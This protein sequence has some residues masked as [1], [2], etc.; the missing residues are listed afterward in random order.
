MGRRDLAEPERRPVRLAERDPHDRARRRPVDHT[1]VFEPAEE[2]RID[3]ATGNTIPA[4]DWDSY[5]LAGEAEADYWAW[6][7]AM[8]AANVEM[9]SDWGP[10]PT[11]STENRGAREGPTTP[12]EGG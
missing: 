5:L 3:H 9:L 2:D 1:P 11:G 6:V 4:R 7:D 8:E 12:R 10:T